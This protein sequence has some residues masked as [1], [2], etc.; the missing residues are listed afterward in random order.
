MPRANRYILPGNVC[1]LT[2]R[3]HNRSF[4]FKFGRDRTE[5]RNRLRS[6]VKEF[7][8]SLLTYCIT[9]NHVH[10]LVVAEQPQTVSSFMQKLEGEFAEYYNI[11]KRR[12]GAFWQGRYWSTMIDNRQ[13]LW[14]CMKYIDLNMIRAGVVSHPSEWDWCGYRELVGERQRYTFLDVP[15]ILARYGHSETDK[16]RKN[17]S[18]TIEEAISRHE[19]KRDPIWTESIAIGSES[20]VNRIEQ[21]TLNRRELTVGSETENRWFIKEAPVTYS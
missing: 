12:S 11:R 17:Y 6:A 21:E 13:Y 5:Y 7:K 19:L 14:D 20:F 3:C 1:H 4:L 16:F 2:H 10:L 15:E 8:I 9:S 18:Y